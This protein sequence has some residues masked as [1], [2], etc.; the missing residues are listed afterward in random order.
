M[1]HLW[2]LPMSVQRSFCAFALSWW[3]W[4][5]MLIVMMFA[6]IWGKNLLLVLGVSVSLLGINNAESESSSGGL[7][8]VNISLQVQIDRSSDKQKSNKTHLIFYTQT[9]RRKDR[10]KKTKPIHGQILGAMTSRA[11]WAWL[12][13]AARRCL[14]VQR[15]GNKDVIE[16]AFYYESFFASCHITITI[17]TITC[18]SQHLQESAWFPLSSSLHSRSAW[19]SETSV[20]WGSL[21]IH[22]LHL[23]SFLC[24]LSCP[25]WSE[26]SCETYT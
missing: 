19:D 15:S 16:V 11:A 2:G 14:R 21:I 4:L 6:I 9:H 10:G 22:F 3:W 17:T 24:L 25:C 8:T 5:V 12:A 23:C 26:S 1:N 7:D 20:F 18:S 13:R